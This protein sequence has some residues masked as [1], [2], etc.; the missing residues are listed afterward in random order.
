MIYF[1]D[2]DGTIV[3][4]WKRFYHVFLDAGKVFG[5]GFDSYKR[6]KMLLKRDN[7]VASFFG[8]SL[9]AHYFENKK[10]M[11]EQIDYLKF[12]T[13][14]VDPELLMRFFN[15]KEAYILS[16]RRNK[17]NLLEEIK[18]LKIDSLISRVIVIDPDSNMTK[19][20]FLR[21]NVSAPFTL[22]GDSTEESNVS[23]LDNANVLLVSTGLETFNNERTNNNCRIIECLNNFL[24]GDLDSAV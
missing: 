14:L 5:I 7:D 9:D 24:R 10:I 17:K 22:I 13:L 11:L 2:F 21:Q 6:Q 23:I 4:I 15:N 1:F 19:S 18:N 20:D 16:K 3:D 8:V 12:D